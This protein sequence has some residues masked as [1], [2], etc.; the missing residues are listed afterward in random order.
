MAIPLSSDTKGVDTDEGAFAEFPGHWQRGI[1]VE[2]GI[3]NSLGPHWTEYFGACL[4][5]DPP[6]ADWVAIDFETAT[7]ERDSACA[8]G[9]AHV[10]KTEWPSLREP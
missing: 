7:S 2:I 1:V 3:T 5:A 8:I 4:D 9:M 6:E 10:N